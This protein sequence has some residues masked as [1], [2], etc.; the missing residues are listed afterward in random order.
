MKEESRTKKSIKNASVN[1]FFFT[2]Q[3]IVGFWSRKV[4]YDYL[5]SEVLGLDTTAQS[6]LSFLNIAESGVGTA[7]AYFLYA[8]FFKKDTLTI[9]EIVTLQGWIYRRI[10]TFILGTSLLLMMFFPLIF[11]NISVPLW[12]AYATFSVLLFGN[13]LGYYVNYRQSV[14]AADQKQYKV[15]K[16]TQTSN[17]LLKVALILYL[18]Y[19]SHPFFLYLSTTLIGYVIGSIWLNHVIKNEYPWLLQSKLCGKELMK[20]YPGVFAKMKQL[21]VHKI[22][23]FVII[24]CTPLI[25]YS[26]SSLTV[27]AYYGNYLAIIDK[28]KVLMNQAFSGTIAG[29]GNLIASKDQ[30]RM[31]KVFWELTDSRFFMSTSLVLVLSLITEPF[32]SIWLSPTYLLG[33]PLL[34]LILLNV[35]LYLNRS[36]V[37]NYR[38]GF[39]LFKDIWAPVAESSINL[40]VSI[41]GGFF[42]GIEGVLLGGIISYII[43]IY[44]W[45]PYYLFKRGFCISYTKYYLFPYLYRLIVVACSSVFLYLLLSIF[46]PELNSYYSLLIYVIVTA[47]IIIL[48][49]YIILYIFTDGMKSFNKRFLGII[50]QKLNNK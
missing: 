5:G 29:V 6:L 47:F 7:V 50:Y 17:I 33:K 21:F 25:M 48:C 27:I 35:W 4:F 32:I 12:Y 1:I 31:I 40:S 30:E 14:L 20:K 23:G 36:V 18:P 28:A 9:N 15:T 10:A 37:D 42:W 34:F 19:S 24:Q 26:F 39:G 3:L 43:V 49:M 2:I 46:N 44:G 13:M 22:G 8:P 38:E 45:K 11:S 16:V 41:I